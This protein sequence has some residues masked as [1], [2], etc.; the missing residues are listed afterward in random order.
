MAYKH[1]KHAWQAEARTFL[2]WR[3][4]WQI[5]DPSP[6]YKTLTHWNLV[7]TLETI[8]Q[9]PEP[10][11]TKVRRR[12]SCIYQAAPSDDRAAEQ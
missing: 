6:R 12:G 9:I 2:F 7:E 1:F 11:R 10:Y 8:E 5:D 3:E 4:G